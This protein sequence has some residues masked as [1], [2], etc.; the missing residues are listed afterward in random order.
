MSRSNYFAKIQNQ[1]NLGRGASE[2]G[3]ESR[4]T[5]PVSLPRTRHDSHVAAPCPLHSCP[6]THAPQG[7]E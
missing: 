2:D 7:T 4:Q 6:L 1:M 5:T 3:F